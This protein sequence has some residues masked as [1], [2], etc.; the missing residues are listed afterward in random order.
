MCRRTA[1]P[2]S[3]RPCLVLRAPRGR[4]HVCG[5]PRRWPR[6]A[7]RAADACCGQQGRAAEPSPLPP[8][9]NIWSGRPRRQWGGCRH[10]PRMHRE[11]RGTAP[12]SGEIYQRRPDGSVEGSHAIS[13]VP[14]FPHLKRRP[15]LRRPPEHAS[16]SGRNA[17]VRR[18]SP[19]GARARG[20][21]P[22]AHTVPDGRPGVSEEEPRLLPAP[23][24][25]GV[26]AGAGSPQVHA[27]PK[28]A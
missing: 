8:G 7:W 27:V 14:R 17:R 26:P 22:R 2:A 24:E 28:P 4:H 16:P 5:L 18:R 11:N 25:W 1:C 23:S 15:P 12:G 10:C 6:P 19:C 13:G 9:A 21:A 20:R 3:S